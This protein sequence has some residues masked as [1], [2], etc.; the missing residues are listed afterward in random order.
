MCVCVRVC[1][2]T[3]M[4]EKCIM[5]CSALLYLLLCA[6][7]PLSRSVRAIQ[8]PYLYVTCGNAVCLLHVCTCSRSTV[9]SYAVHHFCRHTCGDSVIDHTHTL[10]LSNPRPP[11]RQ[12]GYTTDHTHHLSVSPPGQHHD[13]PRSLPPS[14][15]ITPRCATQP[16][17]TTMH[18]C[19]RFHTL[20]SFVRKHILHS[21]TELN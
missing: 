21:R 17:L 20:C 1:V 16:S 7:P 8:A 14:P 19:C 2:F 12:W 15:P 6:P 13:R 4:R 10:A 5:R 18:T 9:A 11:P 3:A